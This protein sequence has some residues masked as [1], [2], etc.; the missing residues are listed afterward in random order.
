MTPDF[1]SDRHVQRRVT[2]LCFLLYLALGL[3]RYN[4][5]ACL[6]ALLSTEPFSRAAAGFIGTVSF[7]AFALG[8]ALSG[9]VAD[10]MSPRRLVFAALLVS[11]LSNL[12]FYFT[13][14]YAVMLVVWA[15]NGLSHGPAFS[16][17]MRLLSACY[18]RER[19][20]GASIAVQCAFFIGM[21]LAYAVSALLIRLCSWREAFLAAAIACAAFAVVWNAGL[22][23]ADR[24][25]DAQQAEAVRGGAPAPAAPPAWKLVCG[26]G[27]VLVPL[28]LAV[29][30]IL[31][32]GVTAWGPAYVGDL[33][34][35]DASLAVAAS[36]VIPFIS[37]V[38]IFTADLVRRV[39]RGN[40]LTTAGVFFVCS[41]MMLCVLLFTTGKSLALSLLLLAVSTACM[42]ATNAMLL[43]A[44]PLQ[45]G[46]YGRTGALSAV[47]NTAVYTGSGLSTCGIG[48]F[49]TALGWRATNVLWLL[50]A[51]LAAAACLLSARRWQ[52]CKAER[53]WS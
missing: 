40:E 7:F 3:A 14:S 21:G 8:T 13:R 29:Q 42:S 1:P 30:G 6:S 26:A 27:L 44:L 11:A 22:R 37:I 12:A 10:R 46:A 35:L 18:P 15:I 25:T 41:G 38:G 2:V 50:L 32:D 52:R 19:V 23:C 9:F 17:V 43:N 20:T 28:A 24:Y 5:S 39:L 51:A 48:L 45:F 31:R 16:C 36:M 49:V 33:F 47:F 4:Y 34:H 53:G